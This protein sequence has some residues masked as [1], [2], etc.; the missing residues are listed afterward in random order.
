MWPASAPVRLSLVSEQAIRILYH[1]RTQAEDAQGIHI[2]EIVAALRAL[3]H[4]VEIAGL[5]RPEGSGGSSVPKRPGRLRALGNWLSHHAPRWLYEMM[6]IGYNLYGFLDLRRRMAR[7]KPDMIYERY[8]LYTFCGLWAAR[9]RGI[10]HILEVNAPLALQ[11]KELGRLTFPWLARWFECWICSNSTW[12]LAV[13]QSM[14]DLLVGEGVRAAKVRV[15]PNGIDASVFRPD[16]SGDAIRA[17]HGLTGKQV[18][19]FVGWFRPW[20]GLEML[21]EL[22]ADPAFAETPIHLMLVGDGP[23]APELRRLA[24]ER[25]V[26][27]RVTFAGAIGRSEIP[28]H[29]ATMD[30]AVQPSAPRYACPMK[31]IEYMGMGRCIVAADQ[32]NI[33][34]LIEEGRTGYLFPA[35]SYEGLRAVLTGL[36]S[37]PAR[38]TAA[39][40]NAREEIFRRGLLWIENAR[41]AVAMA[42]PARAE[43][44]GNV[45]EPSRA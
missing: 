7:F 22:V 14:K 31:I 8:A 4:E 34:E 36:L 1:H 40:A 42:L 27:S 45:S 23:A 44:M 18:V 3:G 33:R 24:E 26:S 15:M 10:P 35:G 29:I 39:G 2:R 11:Q 5:I 16:V 43:P 17:R 28:A 6:A 37:D 12:T 21:I 20:H 32:P 25:G 38:R 41:K 9:S 13:T 19:G 30:V